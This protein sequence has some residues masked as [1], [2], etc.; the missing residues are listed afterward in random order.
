MFSSKNIPSAKTQKKVI[1]ISRS[2]TGSNMLIKYLKKIPDSFIQGEI[3]KVKKWIPFWNKIPKLF[4]ESHLGKFNIV[5]FKYF[6]YHPT[7]DWDSNNKLIEYLF[8][9]TEIKVIHWVREDLFAV[10]MS[11]YLAYET[12][13]WVKSK[14]KVELDK[15]TINEAHFKYVLE[16]SIGQIQAIRKT[17]STHPN[18]REFSF[19]DVVK[20]EKLND[21][22]KFLGFDN[23][24]IKHTAKTSQK[25]S[26]KYD[27]IVNID[28]LLRIY[29]DRMEQINQEFKREETW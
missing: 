18:Y 10:L 16:K 29:N 13:Q 22:Y 23:I 8:D 14:K 9:H 6:Y 15:F 3:M 24:D 1:I 20:R 7:D 26:K 4:Y 25:S 5:G 12:G 17:F 19:E 28:K 21:I 2:R 11:W 27:C